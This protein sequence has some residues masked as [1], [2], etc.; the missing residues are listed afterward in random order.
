MLKY[1]NCVSFTLP[2]TQIKI[3]WA[4]GVA[5][6]SAGYDDANALALPSQKRA[7]KVQLSKQQHVKILTKKQRKHLQQ[8]VDKKK[9]KECVSIF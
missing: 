4:E 5:E 1:I 3:E 2:I 9:K 6:A 7:T 8:I